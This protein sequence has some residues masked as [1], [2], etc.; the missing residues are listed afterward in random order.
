[1]TFLFC[2][3]NDLSCMENNLQITQKNTQIIIGIFILTYTIVFTS[4]F[5]DNKKRRYIQ[6]DS[7]KYDGIKYNILHVIII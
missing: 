6:N 3:P 7:I 4:C 2:F 1:M 5:F